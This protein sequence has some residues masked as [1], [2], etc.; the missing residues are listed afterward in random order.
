MHEVVK[1]LKDDEVE[2]VA[3]HVPDGH[4]GHAPVQ[5]GN[6]VLF[7][8][9]LH[10][11]ARSVVVASRCCRS[12]TTERGDGHSCPHNHTSNELSFSSSLCTSR[13]FSSNWAQSSFFL[14]LDNFRATRPRAPPSPHPPCGNFRATGHRD[15]FF[16][17]SRQF[18]SNRAQSSFF[19][20]SPFSPSRRFPCS[21]AQTDFFRTLSRRRVCPGG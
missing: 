19:S 11:L 5:P 9:L 10:T 3:R 17:P 12:H 7:D 4:G 18:S 20:F 14:L 21:R 6:A 15:F 13:Q 1:E 8:D 2:A 16:S